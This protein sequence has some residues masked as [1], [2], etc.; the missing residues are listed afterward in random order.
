MPAAHWQALAVHRQCT[1][2]P[3]QRRRGSPLQLQSAHICRLRLQKSILS[4]C[5]NHARGE[6]TQPRSR[7]EDGTAHTVRV[8]FGID[9]FKCLGVCQRGIED[10][11]Q[12]VFSLGAILKW[13]RRLTRARTKRATRNAKLLTSSDGWR[14]NRSH[15]PRLHFACSSWQCTIV[16]SARPLRTKSFKAVKTNFHELYAKKHLKP[17]SDCR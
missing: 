14:V 3:W 5:C 6:S 9:C 8:K 10:R 12:V 13:P 2:T 7:K 17:A 4:P 11:C 1:H 16:K 15:L